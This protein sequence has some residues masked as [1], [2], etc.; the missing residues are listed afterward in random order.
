MHNSRQISTTNL[1]I[2]FI[3]IIIDA[4]NQDRHK[5]ELQYQPSIG[6]ALDHMALNYTGWD[7]TFQLEPG[8]HGIDGND[9]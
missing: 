4:D 6:E 2:K 7:L 9:A 1:R 8:I 3:I 5:Q